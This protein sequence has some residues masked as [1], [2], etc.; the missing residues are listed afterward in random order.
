MNINVVWVSEGKVLMLNKLKYPSHGDILGEG[1]L[2]RNPEIFGRISIVKELNW[3][4]TGSCCCQ[5]I[6]CSF[7]EPEFQSSH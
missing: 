4:V 2:E 7:H 1:S 3:Q 6:S 5:A